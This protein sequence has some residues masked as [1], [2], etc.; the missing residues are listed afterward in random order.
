M[1]DWHA[2]LLSYK[3]NDYWRVVLCTSLLH[4]YSD[5]D[6]EALKK[7]LVKFYYQNWVAGQTR[8]TRSQTCC[9]IIIAL[10]EKKS[11]R[12]I[13]SIVVKKYLDDKNITQRFRDNLQDSN[14]YTKFYYTS[15]TPKKIHGSNPFSF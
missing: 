13:A 7:L 2:H 5:Q 14:L 8:S 12:Y 15:K 11:V 1:Q 10:K 9:N 6:I 4:H 3:D